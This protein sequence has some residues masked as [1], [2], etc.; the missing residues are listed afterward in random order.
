MISVSITSRPP[1]HW[2]FVLI[3]AIIYLSRLPV[4]TADFEVV[5][6][7]THEYNKAKNALVS[8]SNGVIKV[9]FVSEQAS[10]GYTLHMNSY[11]WNNNGLNISSSG[12]ADN[13]V[14]SVDIKLESIET[15]GFKKV[16]LCDSSVC[17]SYFDLGQSLRY[18]AASEGRL[19]PGGQGKKD[20][21]ISLHTI[22]N[23]DKTVY[24][25][26]LSDNS[27]AGFQIATCNT[28]SSTKW[29]SPVCQ[30]NPTTSLTD[31]LSATFAYDSASDTLLT[32]AVMKKGSTTA[33]CWFKFNLENPPTSINSAAKLEL[34]SRGPSPVGLAV[35]ESV[36]DRVAYLSYTD[37][38]I[39]KVCSIKEIYCML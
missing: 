14:S 31:V 38:Y 11:E 25:L 18:Q 10:S 19:C 12:T 37:G 20:K 28:G 23:S 17:F 9:I 4:T 2:I 26:A 13:P 5:G 36:E 35:S 22:N 39:K 1:K 27:G 34:P 6:N 29:I 33:I 32:L 21:L 8:Y 3:T 7:Q 30:I 16:K 24:V 15:V